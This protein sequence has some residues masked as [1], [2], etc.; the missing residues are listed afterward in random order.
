MASALSALSAFS[1]EFGPWDAFCM[2]TAGMHDN[3]GP[4]PQMRNVLLAPWGVGRGESAA[5]LRAHA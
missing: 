5:R 2:T 1:V 4:L 3:G